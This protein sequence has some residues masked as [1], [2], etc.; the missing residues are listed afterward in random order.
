MQPVSL[1]MCSEYPGI[2]ARGRG[3]IGRVVRPAH[4]GARLHLREQAATINTASDVLVASGIDTMK[5]RR[6]RCARQP[7]AQSKRSLPL[8][9]EGPAVEHVLVRVEAG[10][11]NGVDHALRL[12]YVTAMYCNVSFR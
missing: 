3:D 8:V 4:F 2:S 11:G 10:I 5:I 7:C 1:S 9:Y 6:S 12:G